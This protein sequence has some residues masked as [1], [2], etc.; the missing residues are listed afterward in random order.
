MKFVKKF[1]CG[2]GMAIFSITNASAATFTASHV[3]DPAHI[4]VGGFFLE[5][6]NQVYN[7]G[8][9]DTID[10]T[11][12]FKNNA[13]VTFFGDVVF[14]P[15]IFA[16]DGNGTFFVDTNFSFINGSANTISPIIKFREP[17]GSLNIGT[18]YSPNEYKTNS[19]PVTFSGFQTKITIVG[20]TAGAPRNF[21]SIA[22]NIFNGT[23]TFTAIPEPATW[24]MMLIGFGGIGASMRA[25]RQNVKVGFSA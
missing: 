9:G 25:R 4:T 7:I 2:I 11:V 1:T 12:T 23:F 5:S 13:R 15:T 8:V 24:A 18:S 19:N 6:L 22:I 20:A 16:F 17:V 3:Y 10:L 21:D 14:F